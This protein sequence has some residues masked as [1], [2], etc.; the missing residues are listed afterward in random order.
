M[1]HSFG[2]LSVWKAKLCLQMSLR[3]HLSN[4]ERSRGYILVFVFGIHVVFFILV[5]VTIS[6]LVG[7]TITT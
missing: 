4:N 1:V 6:A 5:G 3:H 2:S 7:V